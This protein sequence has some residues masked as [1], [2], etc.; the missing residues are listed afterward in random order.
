MSKTLISVF[1]LAFSVSSGMA[2]AS[3]K[4]FLFYP[5][6]KLK[7]MNQLD[8][9]NACPAGSR[10]PT[11]RELAIESVASGAKGILEFAQVDPKSIPAGYSLIT[12]LNPNGQ[13]DKFY[14][15]SEG[16][17]Y[18]DGE[19]AW[20]WSSSMPSSP[21]EGQGV[22]GYVHV[23]VPYGFVI[24]GTSLKDNSIAVRCFTGQ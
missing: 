16:Y 1:F 9:A 4:F 17:V 5:D 14:F 11:V 8:A 24:G 2:Q 12:A 3:D 19:G 21:E 22:Y 20:Y 7:Y 10:L 6:G 13:A 23:G 15:N 18:G